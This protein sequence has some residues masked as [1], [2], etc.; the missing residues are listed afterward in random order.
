MNSSTSTAPATAVPDTQHLP[1]EPALLKAMLAEVL[2]E[3]R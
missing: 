3:L 1:D 2:F